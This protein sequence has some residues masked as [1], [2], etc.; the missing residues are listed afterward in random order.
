M[1]LKE[2]LKLENPFTLDCHESLLNIYFTA[3]CI[4]KQGA[5]FLKPFGL[6]VVQLNLMMMIGHQAPE[7]EGLSQARI[8][9]LM[10]V[11]R[12]NITTLT[13]RMEK[14]GL[15]IRTATDD[16]RYNI[17]K[18]TKQ[19]K[20]LLAKVEPLYAKEVTRIMSPLN[21]T[22][23]KNLIKMLEKVRDNMK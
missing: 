9:E 21:K 1:S 13:D 15:V 20:K 7:G 22:E 2:E 12:A 23:Q 8:S 5:E 4:K 18:L 11:N 14:A 17:I 6:T 3:T 16:R 19:G 10:L